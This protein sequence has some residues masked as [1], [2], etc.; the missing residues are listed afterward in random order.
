MSIC[1]EM[2]LPFTSASFLGI[3]SV[4]SDETTRRRRGRGSNRLVFFGSMSMR[5]SPI[6]RVPVSHPRRLGGRVVLTPRNA[7]EMLALRKQCQ[8]DPDHDD[9]DFHAV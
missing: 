2:V 9:G 5:A 4:D 1:H 3:T 6:S 8:H 7:N